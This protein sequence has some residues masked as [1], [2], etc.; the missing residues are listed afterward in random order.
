M[1]ILK[2]INQHLLCIYYAGHLAKDCDLKYSPL[3]RPLFRVVIR[4][5]GSK[6][7][8]MVSAE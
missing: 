8:G 2:L 4:L 3:I 7:P 1:K 5:R 6:A